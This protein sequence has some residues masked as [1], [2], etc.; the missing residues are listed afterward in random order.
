[1]C[2]PGYAPLVSGDLACGGP[3]S[4]TGNISNAAGLASELCTAFSSYFE[5]M[6]QVRGRGSAEQEVF[7]AG[8]FM[9]CAVSKY[10]REVKG[11]E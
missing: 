10:M 1:M 7:G 3:I 9:S 6:V 2:F 4:L 5:L 11:Q 8:A